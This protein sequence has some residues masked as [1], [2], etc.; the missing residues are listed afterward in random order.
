M[1]APYRPP[2]PPDKRSLLDTLFPVNPLEVADGLTNLATQ[3][4]GNAAGDA[5]ALTAGG[6]SSGASSPADS[7]SAG[8]S[9]ASPFC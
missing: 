8:A 6:Q 7:A 2:P 9:V 1:A 5:A 4:V 3:G